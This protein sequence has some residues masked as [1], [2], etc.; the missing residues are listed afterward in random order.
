MVVVPLYYTIRRVLTPI[1]NGRPEFLH[2]KNTFVTFLIPRCE[3][4]KQY[5]KYKLSAI[6]DSAKFIKNRE[7]FLKFKAKFEAKF[8]KPSDIG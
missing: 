4:I 8:E 7:Y 6:N 2:T 1:L 3:R 5:R